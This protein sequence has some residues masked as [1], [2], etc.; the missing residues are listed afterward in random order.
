MD[1]W[2][3]EIFNGLSCNTQ[4]TPP[5]LQYEGSKNYSRKGSWNGRYGKDM[6]FIR[7]PK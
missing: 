4:P 2:L 7:S 1:L 6:R 5:E 3:V